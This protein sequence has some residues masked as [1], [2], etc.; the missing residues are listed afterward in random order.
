MSTNPAAEP[1]WVAIDSDGNG[2]DSPNGA[3]DLDVGSP[4][5]RRFGPRAL[6]IGAVAGVALVAALAWG[7]RRSEPPAIERLSQAS[8]ELAEMDSGRMTLRVENFDRN[9]AAAVGAPSADQEIVFRDFDYDMSLRFLDDAGEP[10]DERW[11]DRRNRFVGGQFFSRTGRDD[12]WNEGQYVNE[13]FFVAPLVRRTRP[14]GLAAIIDRATTSQELRETEGGAQSEGEVFATTVSRRDMQLLDVDF[15]FEDRGVD[16]DPDELLDATFVIADG[17]VTEAVFSSRFEL[18]VATTLT[19]RLFTEEDGG[20]AID[21]ARLQVPP[22]QEVRLA[23][24]QLADSRLIQAVMLRRPFLCREVDLA[25]ELDEDAR[26]Q[27]KIRCFQAA[28]EPEAAMAWRDLN[29]R[30]S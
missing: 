6:L 16:A 21:P 11:A 20:T 5:P 1:L 18:P 28:G 3:A 26:V 30:G 4:R 19:Y 24:P 8:A 13:L 23:T 12:R 25:T 9:L 15:L 29:A 22:E 17:R 10:V 27:E 2:V 14:A 7:L